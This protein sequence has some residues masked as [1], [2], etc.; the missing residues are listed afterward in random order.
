M[1]E[2]GYRDQ[3]NTSDYEGDYCDTHPDETEQEFWD[4]E[5]YDDD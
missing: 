1:S 4:H 5:D 3:D 2:D